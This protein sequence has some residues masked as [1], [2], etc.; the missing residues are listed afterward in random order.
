MFFTIVLLGP[1]LPLFTLVLCV[2]LIIFFY[3]SIILNKRGKLLNTK[4]A[5]ADNRMTGQLADSI[6]NILAVKSFGQDAK[7]RSYTRARRSN[8]CT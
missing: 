4:I 7:R 2:L 1:R 8:K 5:E 3:I 6:G